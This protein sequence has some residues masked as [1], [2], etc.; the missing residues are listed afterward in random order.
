MITKENWKSLSSDKTTVKEIIHLTENGEILSTDTNI[1]KMFNDYL[2]NVVQNL[3]IPRENS[4]LNT[5]LW[6]NKVLAVIEKYKHYPSIISINE[7]MRRGD[8]PKFSLQFAT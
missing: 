8:Q 6:I 2:S 4:L 7:K 3:N 5:D 1:V